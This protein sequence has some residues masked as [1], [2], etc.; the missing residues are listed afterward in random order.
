[1]NFF[2]FFLIS[3]FKFLF[4]NFFFLKIC[5]RGRRFLLKRLI[6]TRL[7]LSFTTHHPPP[8]H[9]KTTNLNFTG[10]FFKRSDWLNFFDRL[11]GIFADRILEAHCAP[12]F[13]I[14]TIC[15]KYN[16]YNCFVLIFTVVVVVLFV[17]DI[18][19][20]TVYCCCILFGLFIVVVFVYCCVCCCTFCF[21][22]C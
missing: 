12:R 15:H 9:K 2:S 10:F 7:I 5:G 20:I 11:L 6:G 19:F 8:T 21:V 14:C 22:A 4:L 16:F 17:T 1:M 13:E 18:F 3:V